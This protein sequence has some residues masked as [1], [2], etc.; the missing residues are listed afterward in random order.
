M[1]IQ[2]YQV[3]AF[4]DTLFKGNPAA[5]CPLDQWL[6]DT[7][8]QQI[9][10]ENNLSETAFIVPKG[11]DFE[12]RW[13]T[14]SVEVKLCGHATL[15]SAH[16]YFSELDYN[17]EQIVLHS[18][19][20][21]LIVK[22]QEQGYAMDFP[23]DPATEISITQDYVDVFG[24]Q[25]VAIFKGA[26]D[27]LVIL[28]EEA[29][30]RNFRPDFIKIAQ[31]KARGVIISAKGKEVDF[32]SR[33]FGPKVGVNEDPVTGSAHTT[34]APYWAAVLQKKQ[35]QAR[36]LSKRGGVISCIHQGDRV[37]LIGNAVTYLR[38]AITLGSVI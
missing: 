30:V 3:D 6:P 9:A 13:F 5:V 7:T 29:N 32:V 38:G 18:K 27:Y 19:S 17:K 15:A 31:L 37:T 4:T 12:I 36:Q 14:P 22:R 8:M 35:L 20:G 34:L 26:S 25:P 2:L 33:F 11:K 1:K 10:A 16:V 23:A 28:K 21:P 24:Q